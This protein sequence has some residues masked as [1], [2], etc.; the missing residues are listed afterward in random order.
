MTNNDTKKVFI[1]RTKI[2]GIA[3]IVQLYRPTGSQITTNLDTITSPFGGTPE[4]GH[5]EFEAINTNHLVRAQ[6]YKAS[7][8]SIG[9]GSSETIVSAS[10]DDNGLG[11]VWLVTIVWHHGTSNDCMQ[12]YICFGVS[13]T[14]LTTQLVTEDKRCWNCIY[15]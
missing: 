1:K 4:S 5:T 15:K 6:T 8:S 13:S 7:F 9:V 11:T 10:N 14:V 3:E 2:H 12:S